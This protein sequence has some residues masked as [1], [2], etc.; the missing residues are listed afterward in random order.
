MGDENVRLWMPRRLVTS[1]DPQANYL[2][3]YGN[4]RFYLAL[5]N[6]S[7]DARKVTVTLDRERVP[8]VPG[9]RIQ[10]PHLGGRQARRHD[11]SQ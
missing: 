7:A 2:T 10:R 5:S 11:L 6:E 9:S 8:Y 3:G 4:D 1:N